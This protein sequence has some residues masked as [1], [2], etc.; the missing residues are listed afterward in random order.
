MI[1]LLFG[2]DDQVDVLRDRERIGEQSYFFQFLDAFRHSF[3]FVIEASIDCL[4]S[5]I[6]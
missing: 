3:N 6:R 5:Y 2:V 4:F 1:L